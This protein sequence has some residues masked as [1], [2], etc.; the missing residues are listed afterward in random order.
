MIRLDSF[1]VPGGVFSFLS[2]EAF[3]LICDH[4][5]STCTIQIC[6]MHMERRNNMAPGTC[7]GEYIV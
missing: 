2:S 3:S 4:L 1:S 7:S 5:I 6:M